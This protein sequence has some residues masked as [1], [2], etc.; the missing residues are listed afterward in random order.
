MEEF[1]PIALPAEITNQID[2]IVSN[3]RIYVSINELYQLNATMA[4]VA[5][6]A[7]MAGMQ[8]S[9]PVIHG[10]AWS[11]DCYKAV[12]DA[13]SGRFASEIVPDTAEALDS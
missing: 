8:E 11:L 6:I 3:G 13:L 7:S 4:E 1:E 9:G 12:L 5:L 10:V 2:S